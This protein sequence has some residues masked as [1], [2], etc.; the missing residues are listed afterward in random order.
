MEH[1]ERA[2]PATH[3]MNNYSTS[4]Q[5]SDLESSFSMSNPL[6][7]ALR[8]F[9]KK[10]KVPRPPNAFILYRQ[11]WHPHY[12]QN[13]KNMHNNDISKEIGKRWKAES[14][15]ERAKYKKLAEDLKAKHTSLYP[16]YQY[17]PRKPGEKK[18]R[19][20][21]RKLENLRGAQSMHEAAAFSSPESSSISGVDSPSQGISNGYDIKFS[22]LR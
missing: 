4:S 16:D 1:V 3:S 14:D 21:A 15:F 12:R 6:K 9:G 11:H 10:A 13:N 5:S 7:P 17:A 19:M 8:A 2:L 20:T 22:T 18:R